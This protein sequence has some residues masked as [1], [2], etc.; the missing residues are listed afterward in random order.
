MVDV[1]AVQRPDELVDV[2]DECNVIVRRGVT[3]A[4]MRRENL[5]HRCSFVLVFNSQ[6]ELYVQRRVSFKET[7]PSHYDP[8]PGGVVGSGETYE[9]N[10][11]RELEEEMGIRDVSLE[12]LFD[13]YY[14]DD[15][16]K[17]WGRAFKCMY[18][19]PFVLQECEVESGEFL[20][21]ERV[22]NLLN[23]EKVC[24]DSAVALRKYLENQSK[25]AMNS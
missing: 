13:F 4:E 11:L 20:E 19:G 23:K 1:K 24:P 17:V 14:E 16:T 6:G 3:R 9:E 7:Y 25:E 21:L 10:A 2:V 18:D 12:Q 8:A 22:Q 15:V 5:I